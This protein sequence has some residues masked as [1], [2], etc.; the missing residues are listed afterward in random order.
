MYVCTFIA[1][2]NFNAYAG[3]QKCET[4]GKY[5]KE[6][7][8]MSFPHINCDRRTDQSFR[9]REQTIHHNG[10]KS[11]LE[12]VHDC[13]MVAD[14]VTSDPLHLLE[15]GL[16]KRCLLR[17]IDGTKSYKNKFSADTVIDVNSVLLQLNNQMPTEIHRAVRDLSTVHFWKGTEFRT[18]LL[19]L[20]VIVLKD[21]VPVNEYRHFMLLSLAVKICSSDAYKNIV[22]TTTLVENMISDYIEKYIDIYG[23][24]TI[25]SNVHNL[26]HMI[27]D[28]RRFG[29]LNTI[30]TYPFE[31][32]L[33]VIKMKLRSMKNPLQQISRRI[34]EI[35]SLMNFEATFNSNMTSSM[36]INYPE[37]K[38]PIQNDKTKFKTILFKDYRLSSLKFGDKWFLDKNNRIV[39]F[40]YATKRNNEILL[41]G[42]EVANKSNVFT[43][44]FSSSKLDI[45]EAVHDESEECVEIIS[46]IEDLKCKMVCCSFSSGFIFQPLLHTL[47]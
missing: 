8:V 31:N 24:H 39:E 7:R 1:I 43:K 13:D 11:M 35:S 44:P 42:Y 5:S 18:F 46:K 19:Y 38:F 3:C 45:Y 15:L 23:E 16:M 21:A 4:R 40:I 32:I 27:E 41:H 36:H 29:N 30:S 25:S 6:F 22:H 33:H 17:W 9:N 37:L 20:G 12:K 10:P 26:C 34:G 14:F 28:V 47:C 2:V